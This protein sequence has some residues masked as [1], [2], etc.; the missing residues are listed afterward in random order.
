MK[1]AELIMKY[2]TTFADH[3]Y[4]DPHKTRKLN[5]EMLIMQL[6]I[7]M[8]ANTMEMENVNAHF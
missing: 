1:T 7:L 5:K 2:S 4:G 8:N 6:F 3:L